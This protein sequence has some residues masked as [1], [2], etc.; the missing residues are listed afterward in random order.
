[1]IKHEEFLLVDFQD[2]RGH[3]RCIRECSLE[4]QETLI[5]RLEKLQSYLSKLPE[6]FSFKKALESDEYLQFQVLQCLQLAGI[7]EEWIRTSRGTLHAALISWLL[8]PSVED[9]EIKPGIIIRL[10]FPPMENQKGEKGSI[11]ELEAAIWAFSQ[12]FEDVERLRKEPARK[13][14]DIINALSEIQKRAAAQADPKVAKQQEAEK[15]FDKAEADFQNL[16]GQSVPM[17]ALQPLN[18]DGE[19]DK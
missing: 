2:A 17:S 6:H 7:K 11:A 15:W 13:A 4:S 14:A 9:G 16:N 19:G 5:I 1:M 10:N 3:Y 12:S 8:L 18:L